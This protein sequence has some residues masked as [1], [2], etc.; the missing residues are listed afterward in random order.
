MI[1]AVRT[2]L[3]FSQPCRLRSTIFSFCENCFVLA[4]EKKICK[5]YADFRYCP[6]IQERKIDQQLP[7]PSTWTWTLSGCMTSD[8][9]LFCA[10]LK[11]QFVFAWYISAEL[12]SLTKIWCQTCVKWGCNKMTI[13]VDETSSQWVQII[14]T[15]TNV[16]LYP[17]EKKKHKWLTNECNR[18][19]GRRSLLVT[20]LYWV[21]VVH[22]LWRCL[23]S[24]F[25]AAHVMMSTSVSLIH[26]HNSQSKPN[27][28]L[29]KRLQIKEP[30]AFASI[31]S[32]ICVVWFGVFLPKSL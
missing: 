7:L 15:L 10:L 6:G 21:L 18:C 9:G 16:I 20:D 19:I 23:I 26:T 31:Y 12:T 14:N 29:E 11:L 30:G 17:A 27:N 1:Y 32:W 8:M 3:T 28:H 13:Y 5:Y 2:W 22:L 24:T 4:N 25:P